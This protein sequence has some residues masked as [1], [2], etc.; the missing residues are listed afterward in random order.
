M[1]KRA[2]TGDGVRTSP[3]SLWASKRLRPK[4]TRLAHELGRSE[5]QVCLAAAEA[6]VDMIESPSPAVPQIVT[7]ARTL[8]KHDATMLGARRLLLSR[9]RTRRK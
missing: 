1:S 6:I 5:G 8:R 9:N 3:I 4:I 2:Q 7:M